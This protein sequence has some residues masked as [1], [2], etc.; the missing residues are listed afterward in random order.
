MHALAADRTGVCDFKTDSF[1]IRRGEKTVLDVTDTR[2]VEGAN[3]NSTA[4]LHPAG[5]RPRAQGD[6]SIA[7]R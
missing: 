5:N 7:V 6:V 1:Q 4:Q 3:W 2:R